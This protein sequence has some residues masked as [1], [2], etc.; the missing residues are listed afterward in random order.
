MKTLKKLLSW[1]GYSEPKKWWDEEP[2]RVIR[3]TD[4]LD[5]LN[6]RMAS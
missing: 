3:G 6:H 1:L 4:L 2:V 5:V